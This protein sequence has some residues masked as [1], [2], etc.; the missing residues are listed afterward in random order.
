MSLCSVLWGVDFSAPLMSMLTAISTGRRNRLLEPR[1]AIEVVMF[2]FKTLRPSGEVLQ[3]LKR[4][5]Y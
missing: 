3:T 2:L 5:G 4:P 1:L